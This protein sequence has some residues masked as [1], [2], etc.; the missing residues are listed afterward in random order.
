MVLSKNL[1]FST[2][3]SQRNMYRSML[4]KWGL[5]TVAL[6][7][8]SPNMSAPR[9]KFEKQMLRML[10]CWDVMF[11]YKTLLFMTF[12]YGKKMYESGTLGKLGLWTIALFT[13]SSTISKI[14]KKMPRI[15]GCSVCDPPLQKYAFHDTW[16]GTT[17]FVQSFS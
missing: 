1:L 3:G 10:G 11:P 7:T 17:L 12:G 8:L 16:G 6:C 5:L 13:L 4:D 15:L 9:Q 14:W 2:L